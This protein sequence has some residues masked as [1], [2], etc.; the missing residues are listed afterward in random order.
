MILAVNHNNYTINHDNCTFLQCN[1]GNQKDKEALFIKFS[2]IFHYFFITLHQDKLFYDITM[3]PKGLI[4]ISKR[5]MI[6]VLCLLIS[7]AAPIFSQTGGVRVLNAIFPSPSEKQR[8]MLIDH[9]GIIWIGSDFGLKSYDGYRFTSFRSDATS[10]NILPHNTVLSLAEGKDNCLWIGTRNGL[11]KMDKRKGTFTT[12]PMDNSNQLTVYALYSSRNGDLWMGTNDGLARYV[13]NGKKSFYTYNRK[14]TIVIGKDGKHL[15]LNNISVKSFAEDKDGQIYIGTWEND[16]Y[17]L[18]PKRNILYR[19]NLWKPEDKISAYSLKL[20][21]KGQLWIGTWGNGLKCLTHPHNIKNPGYVDVNNSTTTYS[22]IYKIAEDPTTNT[23][24]SCSREGLAIASTDNPKAGIDCHQEI[25]MYTQYKTQSVYDICSDNQG[26]IW[27]LSRFNGLFHIGTRPSPFIISNFLDANRNIIGIN[28]IYTQDGKLFYMSLFPVGIAVYDATSHHVA[29]SEEIPV[30]SSL[31]YD[32]RNTHI[33]DITKRPDGSIWLASNG[34]GILCIQGNKATIYNK[35]NSQLVK[36]N[37]INTFF[38]TRKGIQMVG[39]NDYLDYILPSGKIMNIR[40]YTD[41]NG[42]CDDH[43][44]DIWLATSNR[45]ICRISGNLANKRT[46]K[47]TWYNKGNDKFVVNDATQCLE[48]SKHR[49]WTISNSG[50]LFRYDRENDQFISVNEEQHWDIDRIFSI[51]EDKD[52]I[53]WLTTDNA[54]ISLNYKNKGESHYTT[55]T[56]EDGLGNIRFIANS[57]F[58]YGNEIYLGS[59]LDFIQFSPNQVKK[60]QIYKYKKNIIITDLLIDG[61]RYAELD[62]TLRTKLSDCTPNYMRTITIPDYIDKFS[63]EF[64][65]LSYQNTAQCKYAYY[66]EGYDDEW[67]YVDASIRLASFENIPSGTY[68]LH[69]KAADSYGDWSEMPYTIHIKVLPPW[70][71]SWWAYLIYIVLLIAGIR[72]AIIWYRERLRTKN[73][74]QMA[75]VFTNI[76][77]ELLTPLTVIS[78]AADSI[79]RIAPAA[80]NQADIIHNNISRLTRMLRQILEVRKAQAGKLQLKVSEGKLGDFCDETCRNLMPMFHPKHLSFE[81]NI[82]CMGKT[83]WFDTDKVE[84]IL[85]NLLSNAVKY[86][87]PGG[88]VSLSVSIDN[89]EATIVVSDTGIGISKD[90]MKHLYNRFLDGDYRQMNTIGTGIGL[91]LVN[92]LVKL[93]HGIIRCESEEGKGTTFTIT[94]P[95]NKEIYS[96]EEIMASSQNDTDVKRIKEELSFVSSPKEEE[97]T[98]NEESDK[99]EYTILLVEDN[100]ELL[101]LMSSLLSTKYNVLTA[102]NGEKAQRQIK[103]SSLDV[104]VTDVMM[105]V[106]DGIE[107]TKWIKTSEDYSQLPVVMLTAKTQD[108]DRNEAYRVGADAYITKPFNLNDLQ[109]RIDNIIA[110]RQ[111]IRQKFQTQTDFKVEEQHYSNPDELFLKSVI[112]KVNEHMMDSEYGRGQLATDLCISSS[113]LY[114]KLRSIT[115]QNITSF[116]TSIRMKEACR[117]IRSNPNIRI[118]ELCYA[119]GFST[120]R[121]FSQCFKKEFGMG[122]KEY[123][124]SITKKEE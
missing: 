56:H 87:E 101:L 19:Y 15:P 47:Y 62:S 89:Q 57:C 95:T 60:H 111:R 109:L 120:P 44:G 108:A 21:H 36:N 11:V 78:A 34:Y 70:Y 2:F 6:L 27:A 96:D 94:L 92:D 76:T 54:L 33:S 48:D 50:G 39:E 81:K 38:M 1:L 46:L 9:Q 5:C 123:A 58:K 107:L 97:F 30:F 82:T 66:L 35:S 7:S 104:V 23:I 45:G 122:I 75:V 26:N 121:Y 14:N 74:L 114:N 116:I 53:L 28:S 40:L 22:I 18:D 93:H 3:E 117:I 68:R 29:V 84:K 71:A 51:T 103:K 41:I 79:K 98:N 83:A 112:E 8:C 77:H 43:E 115:G 4:F 52:G 24:W 64:A 20:D 88:N 59:G 12:I 110:N 31:P 69:V 113:T 105:P 72:I 124:E 25:G 17:R 73:R 67:H 32:V 10:P 86:T 80:E 49:I 63:I 91:S 100:Q 55:Y 37:Y 16:L 118:N 13:G 99:K 61:K 85:Y 65:L 119:V 90:K 42:I 106:M 102:A